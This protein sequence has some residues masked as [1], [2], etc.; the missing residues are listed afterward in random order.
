LYEK[1]LAIFLHLYFC[2]RSIGTCNLIYE[3][4]SHQKYPEKL[5]RLTFDGTFST[6]P[7]VLATNVCQYVSN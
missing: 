7:K 1:D 6:E 5:P 2:W 4:S 3:S